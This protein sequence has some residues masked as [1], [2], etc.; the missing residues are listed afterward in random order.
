MKDIGIED[1]EK[2]LLDEFQRDLPL[3]PRPYADIAERLGVDEE[4]ILASLKRLRDEGLVSRIG[5]VFKTGSVGAST[6]AAMS[7]PGARLQEVADL[8]SGFEEVNHNYE[9]EHRFNLWFV[10]TAADEDGVDRVISEIEQK[11]GFKVI[12]LPML[13]DFHLDLGFSLQWH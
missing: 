12:N 4:T 10:I 7:V 5:A 1:F 2:R 11:S 9:R 8:V 13:E 6:L 3:S